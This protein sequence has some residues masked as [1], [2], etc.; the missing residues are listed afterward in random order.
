MADALCTG[1]NEH[2]AKTRTPVPQRNGSRDERGALNPR[3]P[4]CPS[5]PPEYA[6]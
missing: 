1:V 3:C 6:R 4:T 2:P 5:G